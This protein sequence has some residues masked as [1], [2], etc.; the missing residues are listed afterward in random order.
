MSIHAFPGSVSTVGEGRI[1]FPCTIF[2]DFESQVVDMSFARL[3]LSIALTVPGTSILAQ[4]VIPLWGEDTPPFSKPH[5]LEEYE[6]ECWLATC[7][8]Q[9]V[10][11]T[12]TLYTPE[13]KANGNVVV[14]LPGGGYE[15]EAVY[16]EGYEIAET[17]ARNGTAAAVL[18]YR[19]PNPV[20]ATVPE[21]VPLADVRQA[22]QLLRK[23]QGDYGIKAARFGVLG[24][25]AG[26]H[27]ATMASV[28]RSSEAVQNP[29]FSILIYGVTRLTAENQEWLEQ[30]LYHRTMTNEEV[31]EQTLLE[32]VDES[33]PPAFIV[34]A[35]DDDV[36]HFTESTLYA[37]ALNRNGVEAEMHLFARG[38][39]GFG[40]GHEEDGT[41]QW[42]GLVANWLDRLGEQNRSD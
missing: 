5:T 20:T 1:K 39:H 19:L 3:F 2:H 13:G 41:S 33:T 18:K 12:L 31:A 4:Q 29:D 36:C 24:F 40:S 37:E 25:S 7:A 17:L 34:H 14:V 26:S 10:D 35:F 11:P 23:N 9:V 6:A 16:H 42:L 21:N 27:L 15:V 8:Y 28:N 32:R 22:L 30:T 38:G